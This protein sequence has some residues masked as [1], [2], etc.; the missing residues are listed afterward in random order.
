MSS[1]GDELLLIGK[2]WNAATQEYP[3]EVARCLLFKTRKD[4]R[5]WCAKAT[6]KHSKHSMDWRFRPMRVRETVRPV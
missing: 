5:A 1:N 2:A 3:G 4:A 6:A